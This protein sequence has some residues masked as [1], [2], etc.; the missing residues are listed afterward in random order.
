MIHRTAGAADVGA[1]VAGGP[2]VVIH[3]GAGSGRSLRDHEERCHAVLQGALS[4]AR[5]ALEAGG[6]ATEAVQAAVRTLEDFELFNAG[7]GAALCSDGSAELSAAIMRGSDRAAG[8][9]AG[10]RHA[11]WPIDAARSVLR[12]DQVLMIGGHA[13]VY[14]AEMGAEQVPTSYF[15]TERQRD[16]LRAKVAGEDHGTVG[17]V[18]LDRHGTLAAATS[19]GG[20]NGQPPGRVGDSPLIGAGTWADAHVAVSCTGD[21]EAFIRA[22]A[23]RGVAALVAHGASLVDACDAVLA[24]VGELG[25]AGGVIAVDARGN[26]ALPF[27]TPAMPRGLWRP[28]SDPQLAIGPA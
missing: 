9:V 13:D 5:A 10:I 3:A 14:A 26:A 8:A 12:S 19:T 23:A 2:L 15:I 1:D 24:D 22:G 16:A 18:C 20:I 7:R 6:D 27:V 4:G 25:G 17:A 11:R 21:G 28:G